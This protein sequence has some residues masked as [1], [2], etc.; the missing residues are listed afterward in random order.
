M[1]KH[2]PSPDTSDANADANASTLDLTKGTH[3]ALS[4]GLAR[5]ETAAN[6]PVDEF[7]LPILG[8]DAPKG[9]TIFRQATDTEITMAKAA[10]SALESVKYPDNAAEIAE[11]FFVNGA[12]QQ[13]ADAAPPEEAGA[14]VDAALVAQIEQDAANAAFIAGVEAERADAL[15]VAEEEAARAADAAEEQRLAEEQAE[16]DAMVAV[17]VPEAVTRLAVLNEMLVR[18]E[19]AMAHSPKACG[20][21]LQAA[22]DDGLLLSPASDVEGAVTTLCGLPLVNPTVE[23][24]RAWC[25]SARMA[26]MRGAA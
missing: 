26:I 17:P 9:G 21:V 5:A 7:G 2:K 1:T 18:M 6:P 12:A 11:A 10:I 22:H 16:R 20:K 23:H 3:A 14:V 19:T 15:R 8:Q 4:E 25:M 24:L 13:L